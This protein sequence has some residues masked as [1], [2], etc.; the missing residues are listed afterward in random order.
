MKEIVMFH[1]IP[2]A[3]ISNKDPKFTSTFWKE[4]FK[5]FGTSVNLIQ[6]IIHKQ[7]GKQRYLIK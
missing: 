4:L 5:G 2:K 6:P 1:G 3:I 7:M